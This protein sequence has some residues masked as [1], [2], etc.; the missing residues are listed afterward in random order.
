VR[1]LKGVTLTLV[2]IVL[3]S[4]TLTPKNNTYHVPPFPPLALED[5]PTDLRGFCLSGDEAAKLGIY[6]N[7]L[8]A[9]LNDVK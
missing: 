9:L 4:C 6:I 8:E 3:T 7:Q 1:S 5:H 2:M